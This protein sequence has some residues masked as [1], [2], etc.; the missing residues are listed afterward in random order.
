MALKDTIN[1]LNSLLAC[2]TEDLPKATNGNRTAAQRVR[3][4]TI[5]LAKVAK[6]FRKESVAAEK[7]GQLKRKPQTS[8]AK[9]F[10][11]RKKLVAKKSS[12]K[13]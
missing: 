13:K 10:Q 3:T 5:A 2:L 11:G 8:K 6:I 1:Q 9:S 12:R 4:G 7:S